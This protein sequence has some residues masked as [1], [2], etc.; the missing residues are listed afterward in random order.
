[1]TRI[2]LLDCF[3]C[4]VVAPQLNLVRRQLP[5][6]LERLSDG[7]IG[8]RRSGLTRPPTLGLHVV[9]IGGA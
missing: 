3:Y 6:T 7:V 5:Q 2:R 4:N 8:L 1:M 9:R